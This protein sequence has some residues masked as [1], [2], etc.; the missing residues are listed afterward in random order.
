MS[1]RRWRGVC[2]A[3]GA[4][5]VLAGCGAVD[6]DGVRSVAATFADAA[7]G[8]RC[9]LLAESTRQALEEDEQAGCEVALPEL[10]LG[11]GRV[12]AVEVWGDEAQ[13]RLADDTLFLTRTREGWRVVAGACR[14]TGAEAPYDCRLEGS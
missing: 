5:A 11:S 8:A 6:D 2:A 3:A 10:P 12:T 4:V 13:V 7:P 9:E 14:P 1:T